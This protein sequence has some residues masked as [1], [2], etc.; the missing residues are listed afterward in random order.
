MLLAGC[1]WSFSA[2]AADPLFDTRWH[3]G[4]EDCATDPAPAI[5][6]FAVDADSYILRQNKCVH[7]EAP[8]IYVLFGTHTVFVQDTGATAEAEKFPLYETIR[9]LIDRRGGGPMQ[10]LVTHS[11]GH[12]DHKAADAQFRGQPDVTLV[13]PELA[14]VQA[15]FGF[16][17][18]PEGSATID[19]GGRRLDILPAP[20]HHESGVAVYDSRNH[21]LLTGDNVYPGRLYVMDWD[22]YRASIARLAAFAETRPV[23]AVLGSHIEISRV[24]ELYRRGVTYQPDEAPLA[25]RVDD[26]R[27]LDRVLTAAGDEP[28]DIVSERFVVQPVGAVQKAIVRVLKWF[29]GL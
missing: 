6:V 29:D 24:G 3:A 23:T 11:H 4:A 19:L 25:L 28:R 2:T 16:S 18:W 21:W 1:A 22:I 8:F 7:F 12:G 20:G 26:L 17:R 27:E 14:A 13:E 9:E 5:E 10:M 15:H